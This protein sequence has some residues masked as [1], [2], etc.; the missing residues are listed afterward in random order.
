MNNRR[1]SAAQPPVNCSPDRLSPA[2]ATLLTR[3]GRIMPPRAR[4][5]SGKGVEPAVPLRFTAGYS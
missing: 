5:E 3:A 2:R 1:W 4:L